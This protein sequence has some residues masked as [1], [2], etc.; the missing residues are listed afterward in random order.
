MMEQ[1]REGRERAT[2]GKL[3]KCEG[4]QKRRKGTGS[5]W[6]GAEKVSGW[7]G[8]TPEQIFWPCF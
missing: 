4:K 7:E 8:Q 2:D 1:R 5:E 3:T 6:R